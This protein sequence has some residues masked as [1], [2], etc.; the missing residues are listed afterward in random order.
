MKSASQSI[1]IF[2]AA[3][4][5]TFISTATFAQTEICNTNF[6]GGQQANSVEKHAGVVKVT[7][8]YP[9]GKKLAEK[10]RNEFGENK[11]NTFYA[12]TGI[13]IKIKSAG[14]SSFVVA[15]ASH[16]VG[17]ANVR[18]LHA[19]VNTLLF[20]MEAEQPGKFSGSDEKTLGLTKVLQRDVK[21]DLAIL[22]WPYPEIP[23]TYYEIEGGRLALKT[24]HSSWQLHPSGINSFDELGKAMAS[25]LETLSIL[26]FANFQRAKD[27]G[28]TEIWAPQIPWACLAQDDL[29]DRS[30]DIE[31][32]R[33][34]DD[35][36]KDLSGQFIQFRASLPFGYSGGPVLGS[37]KTDSHVLLGLVTQFH[38]FM[39]RSVLTSSEYIQ[40]LLA[41]P[42][43]YKATAS[44]SK[45]K[46][47]WQLSDDGTLVRYVEGGAPNTVIEN[48]AGKPFGGDPGGGSKPF[49]GDPGGPTGSIGAEGNESAARASYSF[50]TDK[51]QSIFGY[52]VDNGTRQP[53]V[54]PPDMRS[55]RQI[56]K[57]A[58]GR[59]ITPVVDTKTLG[60]FMSARLALGDHAA[61][62]KGE[63]LREKVPVT[64]EVTKN[65][66]GYKLDID[67][68]DGAETL[69]LQLAKDLTNG[70]GVFVPV[71]EVQGQKNPQQTYLVD[72]S[73]MIYSQ[74]FGVSSLSENRSRI[75][76][77]DGNKMIGRQAVLNQSK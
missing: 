65:S 17:G 70:S 67:L 16:L 51:G 20:E 39:R 2:L 42:T 12:G 11:K 54:F 13:I 25:G 32:E 38:L 36:E 10:L 63:F 30:F 14:K 1:A 68:D 62:F 21:A 23:D 45:E 56:E 24:K 43:Q 58:Q 64:V 35:F 75:F 69:Q 72:L 74:A 47:R 37:V 77:S 5:A 29:Y 73:E 15:T 59:S 71:Y 52:V 44:P 76:I 53:F 27:L 7:S 66:A 50:L 48:S 61:Q 34:I 6:G 49:G 57:L 22:E 40:Y 28:F 55:T 19:N 41:N 8:E 3:T 9:V 4:M 60:L 46:S 31:H 33:M 26:S 18:A